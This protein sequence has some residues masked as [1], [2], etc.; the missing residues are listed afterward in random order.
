MDYLLNMDVCMLT[1]VQKYR[2]SWNVLDIIW[3]VW[4]LATAIIRAIS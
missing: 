2:L 1:H 4:S 3:R